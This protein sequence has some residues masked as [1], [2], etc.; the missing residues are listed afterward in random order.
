MEIEAPK[1][2]T[3]LLPDNLRGYAIYILAGGAC[4]AGLIV[5]LG[6][7]AV[8]RFLFAGRTSKGASEKSLVEN[9]QEYPDL[10][11]S[12]GDR[13]LRVEG[14]PVR[15]RLVVI[16]PAGTASEFEV[17]ELPDILEKILPGNVVTG[18]QDGAQTRW[19][20]LAGRAKLEGLQIMLGL[21]LQTAKPNTIG[22]RTLDAHEWATTLRVRVRD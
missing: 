4:V 21:A 7:V 12:S 11:S 14:V 13:Q 20:M 9:L 3:D 19:V 10:K 22:R 15:M 17:D 6:L 1:L 18:G 5:L 16:A 8:I 2:L